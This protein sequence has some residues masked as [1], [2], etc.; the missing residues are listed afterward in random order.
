MMV[1]F[2]L[3]SSWLLGCVRAVSK[4]GN[5]FFRRVVVALVSRKTP[6]RSL[7]DLESFLHYYDALLE[8]TWIFGTQLRSTFSTLGP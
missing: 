2:V 8:G 4:T 1:V 3:S 7:I 5:S 6:K